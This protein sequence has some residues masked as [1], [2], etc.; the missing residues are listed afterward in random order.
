MLRGNWHSLQHV[1]VTLSWCERLLGFLFS[2]QFGEHC[3]SCHSNVL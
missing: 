3:Q 1:T 2:V